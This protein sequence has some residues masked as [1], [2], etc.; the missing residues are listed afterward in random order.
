MA[1]KLWKLAMAR[2]S[3]LFTRSRNCHYWQCRAFVIRSHAN[4][5]LLHLGRHL[6]HWTLCCQSRNSY[7]DLWPVIRNSLKKKS[8]YKAFERWSE[9]WFRIFVDRPKHFTDPCYVRNAVIWTVRSSDH[10]NSSHFASHNLYRNPASA[11]CVLRRYAS[12]NDTFVEFF[13]SVAEEPALPSEFSFGF[14]NQI[15]GL[16]KKIYYSRVLA[17]PFWYVI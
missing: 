8:T 11:H 17:F 2:D 5:S 16:L 15:W 9:N 1:I 7:P 14:I 6:S 12:H 10:M 13:D 4:N 3:Q